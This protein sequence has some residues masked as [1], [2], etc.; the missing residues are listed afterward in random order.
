[1]VQ[2]NY[3]LKHVWLQL[4]EVE[5]LEGPEAEVAGGREQREHKRRG[6]GA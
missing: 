4:I 1:M 3:Q 2:L 6:D 5:P